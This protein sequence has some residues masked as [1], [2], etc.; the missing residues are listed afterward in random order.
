M[1]N[2]WRE[3]KLIVDA[4]DFD[5]VEGVLASYNI[6]GLSIEDSRDRDVFKGE[7]LNWIYDE[8]E[9]FPGED[10]KIII[11]AYLSAEDKPESIILKLKMKIEKLKKEDLISYDVKISHKTILDENW[12]LN[13]KKHFKTIK[14]G[15]RFIINPSWINYI[16]KEDEIVISMD[17][18]IA[19]GTGDHETTRMCLLALE[20]NI[21]DGMSIIDVG[22]GTGILAI[23]AEKL[24]AE[25]IVGIDLDK[26]AVIYAKENAIKNEAFKT[27]IIHGDLM[28]D[29]SMK[30]DIIIANILYEVIEILVPDV[31]KKLKKGGIFISS[32]IIK[33]KE[34]KACAL[35]KENG[36]DIL[37]IKRD[38]EWILISARRK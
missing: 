19:F 33:D 23:A 32:G 6:T 4:K 13:F 30:A 16:K 28:E 18:G 20:E 29:I 38:G 27:K 5:I 17:P 31:I 12:V 7:D 25:N 3:L 11:K 36:F 26:N 9:I 22:T 21:K 1:D 34:E 8:K 15:N 37:D 10:D 14:I 35:M 2:K 24:G